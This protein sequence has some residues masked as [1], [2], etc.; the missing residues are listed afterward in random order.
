[1][2]PLSEINV[3]KEETE[4]VSPLIDK[5]HNKKIKVCRR[6]LSIT[7]SLKH[8]ETYKKKGHNYGQADKYLYIF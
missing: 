8:L 7:V 4:N 1:M 3:K 2:W 6:S 5:Y